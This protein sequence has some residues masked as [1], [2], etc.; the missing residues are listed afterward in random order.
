[1]FALYLLALA[2]A[3]GGWSWVLLW[4][5]VSFGLFAAGYA[6]LGAGIFAKRPTGALAWWSVPVMLPVVGMLWVL[7]H[8]RRL[9]DRQPCC[10][11]VAPGVW[12]GRRPLAHE[13]PAAVV[14]VVDLTAEL[15]PARGVRRG[16]EYL[17]LP[18]L[19][20]FVPAEGPFRALLE[21]I[22]PYP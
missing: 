13:L 14:L 12:L 17:A 7:W 1:L 21:Q 20:S 11:E 10:H 19:D 22:V 6:G 5:T 3:L 8:L 4:P 15:P 2:A 16:R 18:T 9:T